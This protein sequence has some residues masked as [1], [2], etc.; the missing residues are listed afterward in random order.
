MRGGGNGD[1]RVQQSFG[2]AFASIPAFQELKRKQEEFTKDSIKKEQA[3]ALAHVES[4]RQERLSKKNAALHR[5]RVASIDQ[6]IEN[7]N[8]NNSTALDNAANH[9]LRRGSVWIH[10]GYIGSNREQ[11]AFELEMQLVGVLLDE[12]ELENRMKLRCEAEF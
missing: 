8:P 5:V 7:I 11:I 1:V 4:M 2:T 9:L 10:E 3:A 12:H 6:N